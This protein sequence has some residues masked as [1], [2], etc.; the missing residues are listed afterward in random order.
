MFIALF[1]PLFIELGLLN[2]AEIQEK[3]TQTFKKNNNLEKKKTYR[4]IYV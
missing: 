1:K 4:S 3:K 2:Q